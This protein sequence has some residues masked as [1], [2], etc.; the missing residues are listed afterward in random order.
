MK[1][2]L[3]LVALLSLIVLPIAAQDAEAIIKQYN[4]VTQLNKLTPTATDHQMAKFE[5]EAQG[6]KMPMSV[7]M[8]KPGKFRIEMTVADQKMLMVIDGENGWMSGVGGVIQPIPKQMM[9]QF[10]DQA[11]MSNNYMWTSKD[12]TFEALGDQKEGDKTYQGVKMTPI[13]PIEG[14]SNLSVWFDAATGLAAYTTVDAVQNGQAINAKTE[15]KDYETFSGVK[16]PTKYV[17][18]VAGAQVKILIKELE[19]NY[20]AEAWMFAKPE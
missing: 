3:S 20:P 13:K 7:V 11:D 12:Y 6:Q 16:I 5:I 17:T 10:V 14:L 8:Q 15:I 19:F 2:L 18:T 9:K 4:Q 1:R